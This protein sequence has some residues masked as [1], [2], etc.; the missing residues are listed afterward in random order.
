MGLRYRQVLRVLSVYARSSLADIFVYKYLGLG[1]SI[2]GYLIP[3][4]VLAIVGSNNSVI[5]RLFS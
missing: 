3:V 1:L 4:C 2:V 5:L